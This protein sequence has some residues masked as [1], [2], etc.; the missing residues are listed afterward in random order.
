MIIIFILEHLLR[1]LAELNVKA[2]DQE[3]FVRKGE[4]GLQGN[5]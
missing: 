5:V 1:N 2:R 4:P 3:K